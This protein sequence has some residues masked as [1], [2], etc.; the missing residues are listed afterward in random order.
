M[1]LLL[2]WASHASSSSAARITRTF[3]NTLCT[4][5][6]GIWRFIPMYVLTSKL[7]PVLTVIMTR[8]MTAM[9][10][11]ARG[12]LS[13]LDEMLREM[14]FNL[15]MGFMLCVL[16]DQF[17]LAQVACPLTRIS[18]VTSNVTLWSYYIQCQMLSPYDV[19]SSRVSF[20]AGFSSVGGHIPFVLCQSARPV[21]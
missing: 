16:P 6:L 21:R 12:A 1:S 2:C 11:T 17:Q 15:A 18:S 8:M 7:S 9:T 4:L 20:A 13:A 19:R 3:R 5:L 10:A 14:S